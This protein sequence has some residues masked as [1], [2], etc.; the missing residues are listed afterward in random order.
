MASSDERRR[1]GRSGEE[2]MRI[3][4]GFHP[5]LGEKIVVEKYG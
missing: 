2:Y 3:Q 4:L 1:R 5:E